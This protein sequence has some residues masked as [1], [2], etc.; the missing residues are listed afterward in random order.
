MILMARQVHLP[1]VPHY[2]TIALDQDCRV[3]T[4]A[5]RSQFRVPKVKTHSEAGCLIEQW[6][7]LGTRHFSFEKVVE[8]SDVLGPPAWKEGGEREFRKY[9]QL[10]A[11][12]GSFAEKHEETLHDFGASMCTLNRTHLGGTNGQETTHVVTSEPKPAWSRASM[13]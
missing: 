1:V 9:H 8:F 7:G 5:V 10:T 11:G 13:V 6:A 2:R 12:L 4:V 3:V